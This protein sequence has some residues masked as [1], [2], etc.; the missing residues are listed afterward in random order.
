MDLA[1]VG[2]RDFLWNKRLAGGLNFALRRSRKHDRRLLDTLLE[3][4]PAA[5]ADHVFVTGDF[6]NL[7]L[8]PEFALARR[9]VERIAQLVGT[10]RVSVIPG[11]HDAYTE[12]AV[13]ERR[14]E[15]AFGEWIGEGARGQWPYVQLTD[16]LAI[17]GC[18]SAVP[19]PFPR[20]S[21]RLGTAQL[22]RLEEVLSRADVRARF[23]VV[24]VHHPPVPQHGGE[25][26]Q[27]EDRAGFAAVIARAGA[28]LVLHGHDHR[29]VRTDLPGPDGARVPVLGVTSAT[30]TSSHAERRGRFN[31]YE[32][33]PRAR[34]VV[35]IR[36]EVA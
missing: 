17:V 19:T 27:L 32:I 9:Y 12:D 34:A 22:Q 33:D 23:R 5:H 31:V 4:L 10:T 26:R 28:E 15:E 14:F 30:Y 35:S 36:S 16:E 1:G 2:A 3:R 25:M 8:R 18:S 29:E 13:T 11:N 24:L 6:T 20:A 7:A 21:G